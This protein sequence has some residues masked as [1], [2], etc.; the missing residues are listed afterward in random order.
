M[1]SADS[2]QSMIT[3]GLIGEADGVRIVKVPASRLPSGCSFILTHPSAAAAPRQLESYRIHDD[4]PGISGWL[5][6]GRILYDC[7]VFAEKSAGIWYQGT[8]VTA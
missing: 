8:P 6:E 4:P 1:R 3:Q 5:V 2:S 7:F